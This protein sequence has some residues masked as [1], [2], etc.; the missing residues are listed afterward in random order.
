MRRILARRQ[1]R[2]ILR[3]LDEDRIEPLR[4]RN[5]RVPQ[6]LATIVETAMQS[7]P[8]ARYESAAA[9]ASDLRRYLAGEPIL[10][11]PIGPLR[12]LRKYCRRHRAGFVGVLVGGFFALAI[13]VLCA[14]YFMRQAQ[15]PDR[16]AAHLRSARLQILDPAIGERIVIAR[17]RGEPLPGELSFEEILRE[18]DAALELREDSK[19][20]AFRETVALAQC[21]VDRR[22]FEPAHG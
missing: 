16:I 15:L 22:P 12:R 4:R 20:R 11:R 18:Y 10:A 6:D 14:L 21:V 1:R 2:T 9:V 3:N 5:A 8:P 19:L 7:E 17:E 13:A